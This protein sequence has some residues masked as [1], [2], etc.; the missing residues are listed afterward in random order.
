MCDDRYIDNCRD[1]YKDSYRDKCR[2]VYKDDS[3]DSD[4]GRFRDKH[5]LHNARK[6]NGFVNNNPKVE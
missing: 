1:T 3:F 6:D 2:D 4:R 5:C